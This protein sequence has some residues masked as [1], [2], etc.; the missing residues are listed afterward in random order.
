MTAVIVKGRVD[1]HLADI[2]E[3]V[4]VMVRISACMSVSIVQFSASEP[5][6]ALSRG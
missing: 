5:P 6:L 4:M 2:Y 1:E 3:I